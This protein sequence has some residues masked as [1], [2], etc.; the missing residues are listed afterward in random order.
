MI[1]FF[2]HIRK[3]LLNEGKTTKYFKYAIGE[4]VLVAI[5]ILMALGINSWYNTQ[6]IKAG[7]QV[8][9]N[10][11]LNDLDATI[12]RLNHLVYDNTGE[13]RKA[14]WCGLDEAVKACDSLIKLTFL[15]LNENNF[16][17]LVT[18]NIS[19]GNPLLNVSD[20][21]YTE[22]LNTGRLY[23]LQSDTLTNGIIQYY[24]LCERENLY[25]IG[26]SDEVNKGN[27][28]F[29]DGFGKLFMNYY[30]NRDGFDLKDYP[31]YFDR[32][33]KEYYDFQAGLYLMIGGQQTNMIKMIEL[34]KRSEHLKSIIKTY[35]D[36]H[37]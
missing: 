25:N 36:N 8:Y 14:G 37:D 29:E 12:K 1:K 10:K 33:S 30:L 24:K 6:Q 13:L 19:A 5:G 21:T 3:G 28:K 9:L 32:H 18:A 27:A 16:N 2:R 7:N 4:I 20:Y 35:L 15:G 31:F 26:N 22:M 23:T 34:I 17:Y 11:M